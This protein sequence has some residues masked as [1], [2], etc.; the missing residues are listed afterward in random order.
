MPKIIQHKIPGGGT[1][2]DLPDGDATAIDIEQAGVDF[3]TVDTS[4][5]QVISGK[6][7]V[8]EAGV[9]VSGA[10]GITLE[11]DETIT[12]STTAKCLSTER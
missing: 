7:L 3:F 4:A 10:A 6:L 11:N 12:N 2:I 8:A 9:D 1:I 5:D